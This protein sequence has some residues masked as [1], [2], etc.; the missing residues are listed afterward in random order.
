MYSLSF[1]QASIKEARKKTSTLVTCLFVLVGFLSFSPA[2][3][4]DPKNA[5]MNS[6]YKTLF[7]KRYSHKPH[8]PVKTRQVA[9]NIDLNAAYQN[10]FAQKKAAVVVVKKVKESVK[11]KTKHISSPLSIPRPRVKIKTASIKSKAVILAPVERAII[12]KAS[13]KQPIKKAIIKSV[14]SVAAEPQQAAPTQNKVSDLDALFAKAFGKKAATTAPSQVSVDL[15][16]NKTLLGDVTVF[17]NK[18]GVIDSVGTK[19]FLALLKDVV[20][21]PVYIKVAKQAVTKKKLLFKTL[22]KQGINTHY[23]SVELSLDLKIKTSLRKP[24]ILSMQSKRGTSVRDENKIKAQKRSGYLN[25]YS[26]FGLA[27]GGSKPQLNLK[28]EGSFSVGNTAF[29]STAD[30]RNGDFSIDRTRFTYDKPEKLQR[31]VLGDISTGNR[32]FQE[33]LRL[34]GFRVSK[35][36]FMNP[37][38]QIRP[39]ANESFELKTDSEVEVFINNVLRQRFYLRAGIY[40]LEDIGLYDGANNIRVKIKDEFGRITEKTSQQFYESNLLKKGLSVYAFNVGYLS[41]KQIGKGN[42]LIKNPV[43]SGYYQKGITKDLTLGF[44]AQISTNRYLLGSELITSA[45]LGIIK[46]SVA[47]SGGRDKDSGAAVRFEFRPNILSLKTAK[48]DLLPQ[49][50]I[51]KNWTVAGEFRSRAFSLLNSSDSIDVVSGKSKRL[52]KARLQANVGLLIN[53]DWRGSLNVALSDYY[54]ADKNTAINLLASR[55]FKNRISLNLGAHY[56][57]DD[58]FS[59]NVQLSIPLSNVSKKRKGNVDFLANTKTNTF[60]SKLSMRPHSEVGRNSLAGSLEYV[61]NDT[62]KQQN[63]NVQYRGTNFETSLKARN[64]IANSNSQNSQQLN[65]G[66]NS[67]I[68][69]VGRQCATSHPINDSFA[70]VSGPANQTTPI[71]INNGNSRFIYSGTNDS[72]LPDNYTALI[73]NKYKKAVVKLESY[74]YQSINIAE[75]TLPNGYDTEKTEFEV[76]PHYHQGFLIKAGGEPATILD[77]ILVNEQGKP[78]G[79]KGGQWVPENGEGK[80]IAFFSNKS[81]RFRVTSIPAGKYKLELFDYP[82]MRSVNIVVPNLKGKVHKLGNLRII[83]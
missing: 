23:N 56:D 45:P 70:L 63:L 54:D 36:F 17:N 39:K 32:N 72:G 82:D 2:Q 48:H 24:L 78:L 68:A 53:D 29:E 13:T 58:K 4:H 8:K 6:A 21:E 76:F 66:F 22:S 16:I 11:Q 27:S 42:N 12:A 28:F 71:A 77:G 14:V 3:A 33:N 52:L 69:C 7:G 5:K 9:E 60:E 75:S 10:L 34:N 25:M 38:L 50:D 49:N 26:S 55:R 18:F 20:K 30:I 83:E 1:S 46:S 62:S 43:L 61:Q 57:S 67:S 15:R 64:N 74:R 59:V 80:A 44:D 31:F 47:I 73:P 51:L 19:D 35:E 79:F 37:D 40:S 41:N 81:G 65:I